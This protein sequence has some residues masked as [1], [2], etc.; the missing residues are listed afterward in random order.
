M[1]GTNSAPP[2]PQNVRIRHSD[3]SH[4]PVEFTYQ[5]LDEDGVHIW[6]AI[7]IAPFRPWAGDRL[8]ADVLPART[9]I[10]M[11]CDG[12]DDPDDDPDDP[13]QEAA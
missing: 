1:T 6:E 5:G 11:L 9:K 4:T 13:G 2:A 3:G 7:Y 8:E 12:S 10:V